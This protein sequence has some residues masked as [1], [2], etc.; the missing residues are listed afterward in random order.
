VHHDFTIAEDGTIYALT[1]SMRTE[2]FEKHWTEFRMPIIE[3][4]VT[5]FSPDGRELKTV[6]LFDLLGNSPYYRPETTSSNR[7]GDVLHSNTVAVIGEE[8]A[9]HYD[10]IEPGD[11]L[12]CLRNLQLLIAVNLERAEIV[13]ATGGPWRYPHDPDPL[14]NGNILIFDNC[15]ANG[16]HAGSRVL[17]YRPTPTGEVV[18]QYLGTET[19]PFDSV[20]RSVQQTLPN[21]N[22]LVTES[23]GGRIFEISR[24]GDIVWEYIHP[25]RSDD[26]THIPAMFGARRYRFEEL[27]FVPRAVKTAE[28]GE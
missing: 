25:V 16:V 10:E 26:G 22:I 17:E 1:Q 18:W 27:P 7:L 14:P 9:S 4:F 6:S 28:V 11:L 3:E 21:G 23:N 2:P 8:F 5:A 24:E 13:W 15:Y 20:V 12:I 19:D